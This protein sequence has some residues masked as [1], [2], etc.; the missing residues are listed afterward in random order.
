MK[1]TYISEHDNIRLSDEIG[2]KL[3]RRMYRKLKAN[4]IIIFVNDKPKKLYELINKND[5]ITF[6]FAEESDNSWPLYESK[7]DILYED[8]NYLV[9]NKEKNL[10]TIPKKSKPISLY[11]EVLYYLNQKGL[12]PKISIL[13]RLD[14][15][16][17]G[18]VLVALNKLAASKLSPT[19][20]Y[21]TRRYQALLEGIVEKDSDTIKTYIDKEE[22]SLKRYVSDGS[23]KLAVST[24]KVLKR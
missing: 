7:I 11:Q 18:L 20:K 6:E 9:V 14:Y 16:T 23:G 22:S 8:S 15:E 17:S 1:I 4:N 5:V 12:N 19:H 24:Y 3:S 2:P 13:N 21:I 10:L